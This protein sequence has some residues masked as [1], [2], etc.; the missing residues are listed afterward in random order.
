MGI[1]VILGIIG[2]IGII[3]LIGILIILGINGIISIVGIIGVT[4]V[5]GARLPHDG[6]ARL[7]WA[8][9]R[10]IA[11]RVRRVSAAVSLRRAFRGRAAHRDR[12]APWPPP[13][14]PPSTRPRG[15]QREQAAVGGRHG[16]DYTHARVRSLTV[17]ASD[18]G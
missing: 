12:T 18:V 6:R 9:Q 5:A 13:G 14:V 16:A 10:S 2:I 11:C 7:V 15:V 1:I 8:V 17:S 4:G 3:G